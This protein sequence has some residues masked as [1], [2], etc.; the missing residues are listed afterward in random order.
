MVN[1][2]VPFLHNLGRKTIGNTVAVAN[3]GGAEGEAK[4]PLKIL[5]WLR[6]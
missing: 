2:E 3:L 1:H 4:I 5:R 6:R